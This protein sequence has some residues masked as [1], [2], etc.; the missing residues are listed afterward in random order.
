MKPFLSDKCNNASKISLVH[1]NVISKGQEL[2]NTLNDF[3]EHAVDNLGI[4]E[5]ASDENINLISDDP[6]DNVILKY[7]NHP[8]IIMINQNVSFE[9]RF[10]F[11]VVNENDIKQ[12]VSNLNS[13]KKKKT[14]TFGNIPTKMLKSSS[15]ICNKVLTNIWNFEILENHNFSSKLKLADITPVY[16]K[17]ERTLVEN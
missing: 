7:K 16:E 3:F 4:K 8:S 11:Q 1:K 2:A 14:G 5:Y 6:I 13:K 10:N 12:E 9:S 17:N 15:E